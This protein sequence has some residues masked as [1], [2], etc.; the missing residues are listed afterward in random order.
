MVR[1]FCCIYDDDLN[2]GYLHFKRG[3]FFLHDGTGGKRYSH[4]TPW[5]GHLPQSSFRRRWITEGAPR[6]CT[7]LSLA[8]YSGTIKITA[9]CADGEA[10]DRSPTCLRAAMRSYD[11]ITA[12]T[13][14]LTRVAF[15]AFHT[16]LGASHFSE[17]SAGGQT[18]V[19]FWGGTLS[20]GGTWRTFWA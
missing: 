18:S 10:S 11:G 14:A 5:E 6:G 13:C 7:G 16:T 17:G 1:L 3:V 2:M 20:C 12:A 19:R 9:V 8:D 4:T 15:P